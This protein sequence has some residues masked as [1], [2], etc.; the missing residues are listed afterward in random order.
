MQTSNY[1]TIF[2][3]HSILFNQLHT[4]VYV[5]AIILDASEKLLCVEVII[6]GLND[7]VL[8]AFAIQQCNAYNSWFKDHFKVNM[9]KFVDAKV[10]IFDSLKFDWIEFIFNWIK[11]IKY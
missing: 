2:G 11:F 10:S 6:F 4:A 3:R 1:C 9:C 8:D 7:L 5:G